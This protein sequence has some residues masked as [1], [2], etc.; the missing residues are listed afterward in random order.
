MTIHTRVLERRREV[1]E[2]RAQ[3]SLGR[4]F[5]LLAA[6]LP[7][8]VLAWMAF[9]PWLSVSEVAIEGAKTASVYEVLSDHRVVVGTPMIL[10][11]GGTTETALETDPWI[12]E[13]TVAVLWPD[14]V[15]V[16]V[17]E[18]VPLA[19]VQTSAGWS[20]RAGD[21]VALPSAEVPDESLPS[22]LFPEMGADE[23]SDSPE[24]AAAL[25]WIDALPVRLR[26]GTTITRSEGELWAAVAG[27][28]VRLG[29]PVEMVAKA[30]SLVALLADELPEGARINLVAPTHPAVSTDQP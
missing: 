19:W 16:I 6:I 25:T 30:K 14:R 24:L 8:A 4:L 10:I 3:R 13:A 23:V 12:A 7:L 15:S 27:H 2:D 11:D 21:G 9:S 28:Q 20:R 29:R 17:V 1:A 22:I 26:H 5:R 18:R